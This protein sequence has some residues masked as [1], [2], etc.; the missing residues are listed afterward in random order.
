MPTKLPHYVLPLFP[1]LCVMTGA[2]AITL[3][4]TD[5]FRILRRVN[6][7]F[8]LILSTVIIGVIMAASGYYGDV[9]YVYYGIGIIAGIFAIIAT[10]ALWRKNMRLGLIGAGLSALIL[11]IPT[12]QFI[13]PGLTQLRTSDAL[14]TAFKATGIALPRK[15]GPEVISPDFTEPSLVYHFG[16]TIDVSGKSDLLNIEALR[17]GRVI[18]LDQLKEKAEPKLALLKA[19]AL[20]QGICI[21]TSDPIRTL[22]YSK[23][24][25][26][27]IILVQAVDCN[28][29]KA[30]TS[31]KLD[32]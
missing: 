5:E 18:L 11:S 1:A 9:N 29:I 12:Y 23:G 2:A 27:E 20:E 14:E 13:L 31:E 17:A 16:S 4:T 10:F 30:L 25:F 7:I 22:N 21:G 26:V 24:D 8:F 3:L 28:N 32:E 15:G 19:Q 6:A